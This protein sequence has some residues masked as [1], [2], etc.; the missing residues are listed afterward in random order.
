MINIFTTN[1][2]T[3]FPNPF[4]Y[5]LIAIITKTFKPNKAIESHWKID[6]DIIPGPLTMDYFRWILLPE[7]LADNTKIAIRLD[8]ISDWVRVL[9]VP[10][11][12]GV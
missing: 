5:V 2:T 9:P 12:L 7:Q 11:H 8:Y 4:H 6:V 3:N 1:S 10:M